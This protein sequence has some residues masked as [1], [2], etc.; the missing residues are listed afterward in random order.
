MT[1]PAD[2]SQLPRA[3]ITNES[4]D[5][6]AAGPAVVV[7]Y[8]EG[9]QVGYKWFA[10]KSLKPLF[11]FGYGLSYTAFDYTDLTAGVSGSSITV[12]VRVKNIGPR[13]GAD[14]PQFYMRRPED[15]DF[16]VRLVG[17]SKVLLEPGETR[18]VTLTVDPRLL[19]RFD[20]AAG[21]WAIS[22]GRYMV[23]AGANSGD[24]LLKTE[25][26]LAASRMMPGHRGLR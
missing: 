16:P 24:S 6:D 11:P 7:D 1:F 22:P 21:D 12:S 20:A 3:K 9:A 26:T 23:E 2:E 14:I 19:A 4:G 25:V 8:F 15:A 17:W 18:R 10:R 5:R 13:R